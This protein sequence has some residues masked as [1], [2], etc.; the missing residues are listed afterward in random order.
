LA[1]IRVR[2]R[3]LDRATNG[4]GRRERERESVIKFVSFA[5]RIGRSGVQRTRKTRK[6]RERLIKRPLKLAHRAAVDSRSSHA[7]A[8][9][10]FRAVYFGV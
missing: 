10:R 9:T 4:G 3:Q 5:G 6:T 8:I 2:I 1:R 7:A